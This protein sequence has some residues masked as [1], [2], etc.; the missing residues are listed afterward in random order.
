MVEKR[1]KKKSRNFLASPFFLIIAI[2]LAALVGF[3]FVRSY[4][5][6]Y[7]INQE[8]ESLKSEIESLER[9]KLESMEILNYVM[10]S[11]FVEEKARTE[12]NMKKEGENV[13]VFKNDNGYTSKNGSMVASTGQKISNPIKWWYYFT[14]KDRIK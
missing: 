13:I 10:S 4:Y 3:G 14:N 5:S 7:K 8:I 2:P 11:D 1:K 12:L 9:K 6:G